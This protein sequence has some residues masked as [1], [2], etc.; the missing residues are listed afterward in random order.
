MKRFPVAMTPNHRRHNSFIL[1]FPFLIACSFKILIKRRGSP[2]SSS[3]GEKVFFRVTSV[4]QTV[5][6]KAKRRPLPLSARC[7][8]ISSA[9]DFSRQTVAG[10]RR[11]E[12]EA[13]GTYW[14]EI[15]E[16]GSTLDRRGLNE[17]A[18]ACWIHM[19]KS[20]ERSW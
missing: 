3:N 12:N 15:N 18:N 7:I 11:A 16:A 14:T 17:D 8:P 2:P 13:A 6:A 4:E 19:L 9:E 10:Q 20:V 1:F 5:L